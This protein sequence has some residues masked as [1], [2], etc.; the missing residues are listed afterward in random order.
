MEI[1]RR[2]Y[3]QYTNTIVGWPCFSGDGFDRLRYHPSPSCGH[4]GPGQAGRAAPKG[5][6][7]IR[8]SGV[9]ILDIQ[10]ALKRAGFDPGTLDGRLGKKTKSAIKD[11]QRNNG[12]KADGIV[13]EKTWSLLKA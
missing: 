8:V 11:F 2:F 13:G 9:S 12:L 1:I 5:N 6:P 10:R 7:I 3:A 4:H